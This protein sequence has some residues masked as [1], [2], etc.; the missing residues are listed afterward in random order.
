MS[1]LD[2][3]F[4]DSGGEALGDGLDLGADSLSG[5]FALSEGFDDTLQGSS[6][7][8]G[9]VGVLGGVTEQNSLLDEFNL[10]GVSDPMVSGFH[11]TGEWDTNGSGSAASTHPLASSS[12]SDVSMLLGGVAKFGASIGQLFMRGGA[13]TAPVV[14]GAPANLNPNRSGIAGLASGH[15]VLIVGL[16]VVFGALIVLGGKN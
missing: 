8:L 16:V 13:S 12:T 7:D 1:L 15:A 4:D 2:F 5:D 3:N 14:A 11:D 9:G 6:L 10:S